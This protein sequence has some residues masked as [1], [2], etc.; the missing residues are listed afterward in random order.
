MA[1]CNNKINP[2]KDEIK[3][4]IPFLKQQLR[5]INPEV[6][7]VLGR[8]AGQALLGGDFKIS[9]RRG[10]WHSYEGIPLMPTYHPAFILRNPSRERQLK[11]E[12]W[13]DIKKVM[14]H[15]GLEVKRN[16]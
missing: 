13:E 12:V 10:T 1:K 11:R 15:L 4:C 7:C 9:Q 16:G 8:I 14:V 5:I 2:E 6:I 3:T